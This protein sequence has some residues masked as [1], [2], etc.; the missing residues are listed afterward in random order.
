MGSGHYLIHVNADGRVDIFHQKKTT[1][2]LLPCIRPN[3]TVKM[4]S[5][6]T[7]IA[8]IRTQSA[9]NRDK[10]T[11]YNLFATFIHRRL[12]ITK[13]FAIKINLFKLTTFPFF[14][15]QHGRYARMNTCENE[16]DAI[17][18]QMMEEIDE[19]NVASHKH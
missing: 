11:M 10:Q 1:K 2:F 8:N 14:H 15:A 16:C 19:I 9:Y 17:V 4:V 5:A 6:C 7:S 3:A 13:V 12:E 18:R